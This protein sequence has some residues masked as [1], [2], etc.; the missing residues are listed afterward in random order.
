MWTDA[1]VLIKP[2]RD[3]QSHAAANWLPSCASLATET[4]F[5]QRHDAATGTR[6]ESAINLRSAASLFLKR[7]LQSCS[8]SPSQERGC[9]FGDCRD[10][11][12]P[13]S[14]TLKCADAAFSWPLVGLIPTTAGRA[15]CGPCTHAGFRLP[16][17]LSLRKSC[18]NEGSGETSLG[19]VRQP[20]LRTDSSNG[21]WSR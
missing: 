18:G 5:V 7:T 16:T 3:T 10:S 13:L 11:F 21:G 17:Y 12:A 19:Q 15:V 20:L 9:C 6:T 4:T 14:G 8:R 1:T 2:S